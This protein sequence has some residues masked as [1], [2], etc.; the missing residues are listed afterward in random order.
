MK[1]F[2]IVSIFVL[3]AV[4]LMGCT[5][6]MVSAKASDDVRFVSKS[7]AADSAKAYAAAQWALKING[8]SIASESQQGGNITSTWM[9]TKSDSHA[10]N[11][12]DRRDFGA[13]G[14][15]YQLEVHV[16]SENGRTRVDV[17]SRIMSVVANLKSTGIEERKILGEIANYLRTSEPDVTNIG[18][19][20]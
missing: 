11:L 18:L 13:N 2:K 10:I 6:P 5:K 9:S 8:Y 4:A 15:Y 19:Q 16:L 1:T 7:F 3:C 20:E 14:A 12:F 17:G